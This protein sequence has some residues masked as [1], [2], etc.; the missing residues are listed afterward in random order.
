MDRC[1]RCD[2]PGHRGKC[3]AEA[4][5]RFERRKSLAPVFA[6]EPAAPAPSLKVSAGYGFHAIAEDGMLK[7]TQEDAD[8]NTDTILLSPTEAMV[9]FAQFGEWAGL[10]V[11]EAA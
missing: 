5:A 8:G 1:P 6:P 11:E 9:L 10:P 2:A 4:V 3:K 7:I